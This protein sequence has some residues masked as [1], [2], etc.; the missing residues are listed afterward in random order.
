[1]DYIPVN[2]YIIHY[3][4]IQYY[5]STTCTY[6]ITNPL[7]VH[8]YWTLVSL[9]LMTET[10]VPRKYCRC[11]FFMSWLDDNQWKCS[12]SIGFLIQHPRT[13]VKTQEI[14]RN[15]EQPVCLTWDLLG[16]SHSCRRTCRTDT[17]ERGHVDSRGTV[18]W[19]ETRRGTA[20]S[21]A[22][23][24]RQT[25]WTRASSLSGRR[26]C[27]RNARWTCGQTTASLSRS[28]PG[29]PRSTISFLFVFI[30]K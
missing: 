28:A 2:W 3:T 27:G 26:G 12:M 21:A 11:Y 30:Y 20:A 10:E 6:D 19:T 13:W 29:T 18:R 8:T 5:K 22:T 9:S 17:P 24:R 16:P 14:R 23:W 7:H 4:Y 1:M 25:A 15:H